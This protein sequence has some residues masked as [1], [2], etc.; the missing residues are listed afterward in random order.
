VWLFVLTQKPCGPF[1]LCYSP[2][3]ASPGWLEGNV[4]MMARTTAARGP[5]VPLQSVTAQVWSRGQPEA[6]KLLKK[7]R[8]DF[9]VFVWL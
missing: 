9:L 5:S 1:T 8:N 6:V 4:Q 2:T 7:T 3:S